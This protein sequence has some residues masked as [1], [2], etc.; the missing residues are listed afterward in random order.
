MR[1]EMVVY[2]VV[3]ID[4]SG[5]VDGKGGVKREEKV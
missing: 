1:G 4:L 3:L 2:L 5:F